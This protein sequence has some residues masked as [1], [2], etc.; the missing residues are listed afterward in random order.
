MVLIFPPLLL[1]L[2]YKK[3]NYK[4]NLKLKSGYSGNKAPKKVINNLDLFNHA[5]LIINIQIVFQ[6]MLDKYN[7]LLL[8]QVIQ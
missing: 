1:L 4:K 8:L 5:N 6:G 2:Q 7:N 3:K